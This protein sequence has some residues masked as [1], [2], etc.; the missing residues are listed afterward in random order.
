MR[1]SDKPTRYL[2]V[3]ARCSNDYTDCNSCL[4]TLQEGDESLFEE[5]KYK[6]K[7]EAEDSD[8]FYS[9]EYMYGW[10][11]YL[12][13]DPYTESKPIW[14]EDEQCYLDMTEEEIDSLVSEESIEEATE[15]NT[16][17]ID[18]YG[19]MWMKGL[20]KYSGDVYNTNPVRL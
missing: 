20:G 3:K 9:S 1:K 8:R 16:V 14:G 15:G 7:R 19:Q 11:D 2:L 12:K 5:W 18:R 13:Y 17:V 4:I 10:V 6:V